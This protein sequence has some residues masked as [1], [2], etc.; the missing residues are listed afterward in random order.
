[1]TVETKDDEERSKLSV[2]N[3]IHKLVK[4]QMKREDEGDGWSEAG[5]MTKVRNRHRSLFS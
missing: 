3:R 1:M 4:G 2:Y 5:I